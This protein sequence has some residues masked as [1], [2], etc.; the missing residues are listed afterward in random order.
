[1]SVL[2]VCVQCPGSGVRCPVSGVR[3]PLLTHPPAYVKVIFLQSGSSITKN[4]CKEYGPL[5]LTYFCHPLRDKLSAEDCSFILIHLYF[6]A[7]W[8]FFFIC[9]VGLFVLILVDLAKQYFDYP[10]STIIGV[11][12]EHPLNFPS[13][14]VCNNN[15]NR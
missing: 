8:K 13:V 3:F 4:L 1:M 5:S 7:I 11:Y 14:S 2:V 9:S 6:R 15:I 12:E 10:K